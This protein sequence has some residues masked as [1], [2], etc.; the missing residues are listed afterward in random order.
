MLE[1]KEGLLTF[2]SEGNNSPGSRYYSREIHWPGNLNKCKNEASG[3]TIGRGYDL[4]SRSQSEVLSHFNR[5]GFSKEKSE[6]II[7]AVGLTHCRARDFV[8]QNKDEI[9][10]ISEYQQ[11]KLF[12]ISYA[13]IKNDTIR[14]YNKYRKNGSVTWDK[15]HPVLKDVII[16][17]RYQGV[18]NYRNV[19]FFEKNNC[20]EV[21]EF[22]NRDAYISSFEDNRG[23][24]KYIKGRNQ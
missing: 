9:D 1:P 6:K 12:E 7:K 3:V 17:M 23:R 13:K 20:E 19:K 5:A 14:I 11:L 22:I 8:V 15:L 2:K 4:G 16:D 18:L 24:V 10:E 21:I